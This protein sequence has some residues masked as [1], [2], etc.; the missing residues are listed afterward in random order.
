M[1]GCHPPVDHTHHFSRS[2]KERLSRSMNCTWE[3]AQRCLAWRLPLIQNLIKTYNLKTCVVSGCRVNLRD[4]KTQGLMS[5]SWKLMST[6]ARLLE[7]MELPCR[8][9]KGNTHARCEG[10][11]AHM[12]AYYTHEFVIQVTRVLMQELNKHQ[13]QR[14][15]TGASTLPLAFGKGTKCCCHMLAY[16]DSK[17]TCGHCTMNGHSKRAN[18]PEE[19]LAAQHFKEDERT[20]EIKRKLYLLHAATGHGSIRHLVDALKRRNVTEKIVRLA[21]EFNLSCVH[22]KTKG[23]NETYCGLATSPPKVCVHQC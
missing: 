16:H 6:H 2:T 10:G 13:I 3:W 23:S 17:H 7:V 11:L 15:L 12:T 4:P 14:E 1:S 5:K 18:T 19:V 22:G 8:C 20:D 9:P 21:E